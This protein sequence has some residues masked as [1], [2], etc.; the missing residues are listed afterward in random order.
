MKEDSSP[1]QKK[2]FATT[3]K[4]LKSFHPECLAVADAGSEIFLLLGSEQ[5]HGMQCFIVARILSKDKTKMEEYH[6]SFDATWRCSALLRFKSFLDART[7][8]YSGIGFLEVPRHR[9]SLSPILP[10]F[11][12]EFG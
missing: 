12:I 7:G 4:K 6:D 2:F 9:R 1:P 8:G 11:G 5:S 10:R 3:A